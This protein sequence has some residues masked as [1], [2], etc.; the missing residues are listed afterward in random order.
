MDTIKIGDTVTRYRSD[1]NGLKPGDTGIVDRI[2]KDQA[3]IKGRPEGE[4][5]SLYELI[6][7]ESRVID[8]YDIY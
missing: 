4:L 8:S 7:V 6:V 2:T 1:W 5:H 3:H